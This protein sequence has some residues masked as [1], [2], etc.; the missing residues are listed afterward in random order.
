VA[1]GRTKE[2]GVGVSGTSREPRGPGEAPVVVKGVPAE[3]LAIPLVGDVSQETSG[4]PPHPGIEAPSMVAL[5]EM[6]FDPDA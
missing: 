5:L 4:S 6:A 3:G 2:R 1:P